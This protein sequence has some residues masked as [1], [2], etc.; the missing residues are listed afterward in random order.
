MFHLDQKKQWYILFFL[1]KNILF[2]FF[3]IIKICFPS[4]NALLFSIALLVIYFII[5]LCKKPYKNCFSNFCILHNELIGL[6]SL[7]LVALNQYMEFETAMENYFFLGLEGL[8]VICIFLTLIR[9]IIH[10]CRSCREET[11]ESKKDENKKVS[12]ER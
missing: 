8:I 6:Y 3:L 2:A 11:D 10:L 4:V 7:G 9:I 5:I 1:I 12:K